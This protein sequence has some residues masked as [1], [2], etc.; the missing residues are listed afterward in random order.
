MHACGEFLIFLPASYIAHESK[1]SVGL[2]RKMTAMVSYIKQCNF[3]I[4]KAYSILS[5]SSKA[6]ESPQDC[7]EPQSLTNRCVSCYWVQQQ[8]PPLHYTQRSISGVGREGLGWT[9]GVMLYSHMC[10]LFDT[11]Q[12]LCNDGHDILEN[13]TSHTVYPWGH[14]KH[15]IRWSYWNHV[16]IR[17]PVS[18]KLALWC[19]MCL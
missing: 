1:I 3:D 16:Y 6:T 4:S 9:F 5:C 19:L 10:L 15:I 13:V 17:L 7:I 12:S 11:V 8:Q 2:Q 18:G 14:W